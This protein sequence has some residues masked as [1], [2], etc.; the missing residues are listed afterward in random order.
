MSRALRSNLWACGVAVALLLH[1]LATATGGFRHWT[2][3]SWR[4]AQAAQGL[5]RAP[6]IRLL[7]SRGQPL[8]PWPQHLPDEAPPAPGDVL[9]VDFVFT[10]CP[11]VCLSLGTAFQQMQAQLPDGAGTGA[12][13]RVRLL[14][15][16][17]DPEHDGPDALLAYAQRYR[18]DPARWTVAVPSGATDTATLLRSLGVVVIPDGWGGYVHNAG[19]HVIDT[20]GRL[21]GVHDLAD[22]PR[23]LAQAR[24]LAG[25]ASP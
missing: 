4:R 11:T 7:D 16:S 1:L 24:A 9:I 15:I 13:A 21:A 3:E 17:F 14:S 23:A 5:L 8:R 25:A 10:R 18:A 22:W 12:G 19:L 6:D 2:F 20:R